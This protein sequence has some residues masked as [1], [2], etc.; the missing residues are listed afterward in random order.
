MYIYTGDQIPTETHWINFF[1]GLNL[2]KIDTFQFNCCGSFKTSYINGSL[3]VSKLILTGYGVDWEY[4]NGGYDFTNFGLD[5]ANVNELVISCLFNMKDYSFINT[6]DVLEKL[7]INNCKT[8][9]IDFLE[10][11]TTLQYLNLSSN[12]IIEI[13]SLSSLINLKCLSLANNN[14]GSLYSLRNLKKLGQVY[15]K[16]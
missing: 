10:G 16:R 3:E 1:E 5:F 8:Q 7:S 6:F 12:N 11:M 4:W 2:S 14:I 13:S 15:R 9:N